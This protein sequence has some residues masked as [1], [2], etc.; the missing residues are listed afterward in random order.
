VRGWCGELL[1]WVSLVRALIMGGFWLEKG[2]EGG[3]SHPGFAQFGWEE[4]GQRV[5]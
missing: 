3:M 4:E 5:V 1:W 2:E